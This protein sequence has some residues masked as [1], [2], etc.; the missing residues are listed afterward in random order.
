LRDI[1]I[2]GANDK[3]GSQIVQDYVARQ[4][5]EHPNR[6]IRYFSWADKVGIRA[7]I[8]KGLPITE[9]LNVIGHSLGGA[10][11]IRQALG[12]S[13]KIDN[14]ITIDPVS[15]AGSGAK[16]EN[17]AVWANVTGAPA[18]R[19]FSDTVASTGRALLGT[20]D[21]TGADVSVTSPYSHGDFSDMMQQVHAPEA[22]EASYR[23]GSAQCTARTGTPC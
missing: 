7:A 2:G 20:T 13:A 10:E 17:V 19:N 1:Y 9:P 16:P 6:D 18:D 14:L 15:S 12:T 21:T 23:N 8:N 11:A 5:R 4:I 22:I 3:G